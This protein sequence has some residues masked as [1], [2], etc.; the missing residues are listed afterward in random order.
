M[1]KFSPKNECDNLST[2]NMKCLYYE[3]NLQ[4]LMTSSNTCTLILQNTKIT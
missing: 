3:Y 1:E 2:E 4:C